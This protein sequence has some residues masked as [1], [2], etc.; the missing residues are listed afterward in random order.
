MRL[1]EEG[2][3][4][5]P[6]TEESRRWAE[7][8]RQS[9]L[10]QAHDPEVQQANLRHADTW[11][12]GVDVLPND[13]TGAVDGVPL[14]GPWHAHL[15]WHGSLHR[16]QLSIAYPGYPGRDPDQSAANHR[17]RLTRHAA[18]VDGLLPTGPDRRRFPGEF[19]AYVLGIHLNGCE[20][21]PTVWWPGSH[22]IIARALR[23][24]IGTADPAEIDVTEAYHAARREIF[25]ESA[26]RPLT[27]PP[28]ASFLLHRFTLHGT[29]PWEGPAQPEGRMSA[30]FRPEFE[31]R[32]EWLLAA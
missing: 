6:P 3:M 7:A 17:Y 32:R 8:A 11:F 5:F 30:F 22:R 2:C 24:A 27:G 26:P 14:R 4:R 23:D 9:G 20:E 13:K 31:D 28:G 12:V 16:A 1:A 21:A 25:A 10:R 29:A 19:H 15:P 18:H